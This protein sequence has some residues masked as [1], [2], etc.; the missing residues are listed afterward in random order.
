MKCTQEDG[1]DVHASLK[2]KD[3]SSELLTTPQEKWQ[4]AELTGGYSSMVE[5]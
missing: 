1:L 4:G 5:H 2:A 3:R